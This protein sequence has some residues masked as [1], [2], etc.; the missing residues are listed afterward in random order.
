MTRLGTAALLVIV[1]AIVGALLY[2]QYAIIRD[3][4]VL[5]FLHGAQWWWLFGY[6]K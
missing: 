2:V 1:P 4:G 6:C 3:C 5:A